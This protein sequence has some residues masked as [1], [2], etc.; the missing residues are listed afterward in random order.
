[1]QDRVQQSVRRGTFLLALAIIA[2]GPGCNQEGPLS[3]AE[4]DQ[5]RTFRLPAQVPGDTS[6]AAGD[7]MMAIQL[8]KQFFF[9]TNFSG[10]LLGPYNLAAGENGALGAAGDAG[11]V[12]CASCHNPMTAGVDRRS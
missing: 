7:D 2:S 8:G 3:D 4:M 1:M 9:D 11:K 5:L 10:A 6:N 12:G